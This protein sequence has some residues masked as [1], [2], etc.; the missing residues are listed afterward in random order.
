[1]F[2]N[3]NVYR[4]GKLGQTIY[5]KICIGS[6]ANIL[7]KGFT[8]DKLQRKAEF[9]EVRDQSSP[10]GERSFSSLVALC[11]TTEMLSSRDKSMSSSM[12]LVT[13]SLVLHLEVLYQ[14]LGT[15]SQYQ[16]H[17]YLNLYPH[18]QIMNDDLVYMLSR[19]VQEI[20]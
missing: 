1:M 18:L 14:G 17:N 16:Y 3:A 15:I 20:C 8:E 11:W 9:R 2:Q 13:V 4:F 5:N 19:C 6:I 10:L 7:C 12:P